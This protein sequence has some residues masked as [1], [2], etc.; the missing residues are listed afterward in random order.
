MEEGQPIYR[1]QVSDRRL[2]RIVDFSNLQPA[3]VL[4]YVGLTNK[5][6]PVILNRLW[7]ANIC[8]VSW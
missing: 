7:T 6:E 3:E 5:D 4:E 8:G 1:V 2:E